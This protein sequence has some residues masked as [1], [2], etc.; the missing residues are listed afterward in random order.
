[1]KAKGKKLSKKIIFLIVAAAIIGTVALSC[2][3]LEIAFV[4][5][6]GM[7]YWRP[8]YEKVDLY[9]TLNKE[10]LTDDDYELIF[11]QTGL[12]KIGVDRMRS[13]GN[14]GI[15]RILKI[16]N[17]YF[18]DYKI[19]NNHVAPFIC[20]DVID[21]SVTLS[22]FEDG[23]IIVSSSTHLSGWRMGHAGLVVDAN[24]NAI[25]QA[26]AI[27]D[28]SKIGGIKDFNNRINFMVLSP[29]VDTDVKAEV[30]AYAKENLIG[31]IYD[32]TAGVFSDKK[33]ITKTQCAHLVWYAYNLF[34]VDLDF[35]G[36]LVVT[37]RDIANS[38]DVELVQ[39]FG[40]DPEDLWK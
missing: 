28:N 1:M 11:A 14:V 8:D 32:P 20:T 10:T 37:P 7:E 29:K 24:E 30:C 12:T 35:N 17:D 33:S 23:D 36:G 5:A 2:I 6:D 9:S 13:K 25:L 38:P 21:G 22:Y 16:Q 15:S 34:G 40:F 26:N 31:K 3:G 4:V 27:F 19:I 18:T 39:I